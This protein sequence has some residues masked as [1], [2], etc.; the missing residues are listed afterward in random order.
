MTEASW[1]IVLAED[2]IH[3]RFVRRYL[4]C[5]GFSPHQID[6]RQVPNGRGSGEQSVRQHYSNAV[7]DY[8]VRSARAKTALIVI[9]DADAQ[10]MG[11][12]ASQFEEALNQ[13]RLVP[14]SNT[15]AILHFVPRRNVETWILHLNGAKVDEQDDYKAQMSDNMIR[16]A[17]EN[18]HRW[19]SK[20]PSDCLPS[21]RA[22][23]EETGRL[24]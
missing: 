1:V 11:R 10:D 15:E 4:Y 2:T 18:F 6:F 13:S 23:I 17:A 19:T 24:G 3:Q 8:R 14:R 12:R 7:Q 16:P 21:V 9:I 5:L 22:A 20:P